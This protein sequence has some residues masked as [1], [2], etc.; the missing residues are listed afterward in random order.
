MRPVVGPAPLRM[1]RGPPGPP[2]PPPPTTKS[3]PPEVSMVTTWGAT[4]FI[5]ALMAF[6]RSASRSLGSWAARNVAVSLAQATHARVS[7]FRHMMEFIPRIMGPAS[8]V[9]S[10]PGG[11]SPGASAPGGALPALTRPGSPVSVLVLVLIGLRF[12]LGLLRNQRLAHDHGQRLQLV[13]A[14]YLQGDL[15]LGTDAPEQLF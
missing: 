5:A 12:L 4:F 9:A 10:A 7:V 1:R 8:P 6:W 14:A 2:G 3:V 13:A 11:A 15:L